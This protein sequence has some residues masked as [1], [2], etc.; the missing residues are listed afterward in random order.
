[1]S[2]TREQ[3]KAIFAKLTIRDN[4]RK[5][6]PKFVH[7]MEKTFL[8]TSPKI[9]NK[10]DSLTLL[11]KKKGQSIGDIL[12]KPRNKYDIRVRFD[13]KNVKEFPLVY[14]HELDHIFYD[15]IKRNNPK[16]IKQ[17]KDDM[18]TVFPF[19]QTLVILFSNVEKQIESDTKKINKSFNTLFDEFHSETKEASDRVRLGLD[20]AKISKKNKANL[21]KALDAYNKFHRE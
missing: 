2:I 18:R 17:Y 10:I 13:G 9:V 14:N 5:T 15:Q 1:M 7:V 4:L 3:Q 20:P 8:E 16:K 21:Q 6:N 11:K 12:A 19:N